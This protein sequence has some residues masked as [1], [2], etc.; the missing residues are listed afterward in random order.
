MSRSET[1]HSEPS[2]SS[3]SSET[4]AAIRVVSTGKALKIQPFKIPENPL[5]IGRAW[6]EWI[7][8]FE[9]E[10]HYF[11]IKD[12]KDQVSALK[13]Y[14]GNEIKRLAR[15]L[16]DTAEGDN[17]YQKLKQKLNNYFLPK[18]NKHH[19]RYIFPKQ[20]TRAGESIMT[21]TTRL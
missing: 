8:D 19:A 15:N 3:S 21:Y 10:L 6:D 14:G 20:Q 17:D 12:V 18:K 9:D 11:E 13:I 1:S 2:G 16:P 7:E 4:R 5:E